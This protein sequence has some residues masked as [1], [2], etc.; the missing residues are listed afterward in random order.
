MNKQ[1]LLKLIETIGDEDS[2]D[3]VLSQSDFAKSLLT[4]GLTLDAF[5]EKVTKDKEFKSFVDSLKDNHFNTALETWKT[6]NLQK[7][8]DDAVSKANPEETAEQKKIRELT[9]RID[10]AEK[11]KAYESL[12]NKAYKIAT[13]K[14]LP[15]DIVE[16]FIGQDEEATIKNLESFNDVYNQNLSL[17]IEE[18]LK[19]GYK[20]PVDANQIVDESKLSDAEWFA[21]HQQ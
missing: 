7:I 17:A 8:V 15:S 16:F 10:K 19:G 6:N 5:K 13:D 21:S 9:E 11:E 14:K 18:R 1:E 2:V 3:E 20:P 12:R 4:S